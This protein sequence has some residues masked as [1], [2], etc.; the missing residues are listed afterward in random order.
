M[1]KLCKLSDSMYEQPG[2]KKF[3]RRELFAPFRKAIDGAKKTLAE[4]RENYTDKDR[5]AEFLGEGGALIAILSL[6]IRGAKDPVVSYKVRSESAVKDLREFEQM[7]G[8][9][10]DF[11][12]G[13]AQ[14]QV[15]CNQLE[16]QWDSLFYKSRQ[17]L[18]TT[19]NADGDPETELVTVR[20][21][22]D[23][24]A[25]INLGLDHNELDRWLIFFRTISRKSDQS[26]ANS[27]EA[28]DLSAGDRT[29]TYQV[30][31]RNTAGQAN[32][33]TAMYGVVGTAFVFYEEI[34]N[35]IDEYSVIQQDQHV[36]R[37]SFMKAVSAG[38]LAW[39]IRNIQLKFVK[40]NN[41]LY[42]ELSAHNAQ[43]IRELDCGDDENFSRYFD[44]DLH[45]MRNQLAHIKDTCLAVLEVDDSKIDWGNRN[46]WKKVKPL[47]ESMCQRAQQHLESFDIFF[48]HDQTSTGST[49][50]IPRE[51][52]TLT[53]YLWA[54]EQITGYANNKASQ[55]GL[56]HFL[57]A[58]GLGAG[59]AAIAGV[60]EHFIFPGSDN[61]MEKIKDIF[62]GV[63]DTFNT[64]I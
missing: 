22:D 7:K 26:V 6:A 34:F 29:L 37:R 4:H 3:T 24:E 63:R 2:S 43:V 44:M 60:S 1:R 33:N 27:E 62:V 46:E 12:Q 9:M 19:T 36:S 31:E 61:L 17:E 55:V 30:E 21:W 11:G 59:L 54:T 48:Q 51:F 41:D 45:E 52:T 23:P 49:F 47:I 10:D 38:I 64:K 39:Q 25:L 5:I 15:A 20:Y 28:F 42:Q 56:R 50:T 14:S 18:R 57:N 53:K 35:M 40:K 32:I 8:L 16:R 58:L 13:F